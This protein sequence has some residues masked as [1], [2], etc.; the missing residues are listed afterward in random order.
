[1]EGVNVLHLVSN[2]KLTGPV[3]PAIRL[4]SALNSV[5]VHSRVAVGRPSLEE[6]G[7][8]DEQVRERGLE[9][10]TCLRLSKHRRVLTNRR[11]AAKLAKILSEAPVEVLHVHLDNAHRIAALAR[12]Q[13]PPALRPLIVRTLYDGEGPSVR[14]DTRRLYGR[15]L[16]GVFV[17]GEMVREHLIERFP[18]DPT[19]VLKLEGAVV[20]ERFFPR[21]PG[22]DL[23]ERLELPRDAIV[24]GIVA[25]IQPHRRFE[26]L[27]EA[28]RRVSVEVPNL[29]LLVLGRGTRAREIAH[30]GV[31]RLGI[32]ERV[33]LPGY[34]GGDDY[35]LALACFDFKIF[36]VPGSDGTCRAVREAMAT[37]MPV[38][39]AKRG[40]LTEIVRDGE[41]GL[42][43]DDEVGPLSEGIRRLATDTSCRQRLGKNALERARTDF[44]QKRQ[45]ETVA[46]A[47]QRWL[48][49]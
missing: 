39:A 14:L 37:G 42:L 22:D 29:Y 40:L 32:G 4:A 12:R 44:C 41:D 38:I 21:S 18:L 35:P 2:H 15:E 33:R 1:M 27:L 19:R 8:I 6:P 23:R 9:P 13:L 10:I 25:R 30:A 24:A 47:Y 31:E 20:T 43:V 17:F 46:A 36:L 16:G 11:D 34:I 5:G 3:D 48:E 28:F 26:V 45:A 49:R 7:P